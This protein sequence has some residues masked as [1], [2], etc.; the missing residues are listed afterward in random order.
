MPEHGKQFEHIFDKLEVA[1]T[2][3]KGGFR[4]AAQSA[5]LERMRNIPAHMMSEDEHG[6][7]AKYSAGGW[8]TTWHGGKYAEHSHPKHGAV[9]VTDMATNH[10]DG[11]ET[12]PHSI[13]GADIKKVHHDFLSYKKENYPD[14][15]Q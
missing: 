12:L 9:D 2:G 4:A 14:Y 15:M 6:H 8:T 3:E 5:A 7:H 11:R 10:P 13:S 1:M